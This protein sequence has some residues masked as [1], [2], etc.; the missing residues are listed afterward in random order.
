[1]VLCVVVGWHWGVCGA[2]LN[3]HE[4]GNLRVSPPQKNKPFTSLCFRRLF[5]FYYSKSPLNHHLADVFF[6][7]FPSI[8]DKSKLY[9]AVFLGASTIKHPHLF[10]HGLQDMEAHVFPC[11]LGKFNVAWNVSSSALLRETK[12]LIS[13]DHEAFFLGGGGTFGGRL[14]NQNVPKMEES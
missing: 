11:E 7:F 13:P 9:K 14:T 8:L 10:P 12:G 2:V 3:S 1:M 4:H 5:T 6:Y